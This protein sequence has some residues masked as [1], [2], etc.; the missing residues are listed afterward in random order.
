MSKVSGSAMDESLYYRLGPVL[1][2][3]AVYNFIVGGRGIGKTFSAKEWGISDYIKNGNQFIYLRRYNTE[4]K[5]T[6][7]WFADLAW[8]FPE[9][10]FRVNGGTAEMTRTPHEKKPTWEIIGFFVALSNAQNKKSVAYP[11][12]TKIIFDEF[13]IEKGVIQYLPNEARQMLDFYSTVDRYKD[14]TRVLFLA[15]S[16]SI[17]NPYFMEY[18]I[19]PRKNQEWITKNDGFLV[20]HLPNDGEFTSAVMETRF[21]KFVTGTEY[22]DYSVGNVFRDN[23]M[24]L[25]KRKNEHATYQF[26]LETDMG[27]MAV[28][29]DGI[30]DKQGV[31]FYIQEKRPKNEI[32]MTMVPDKMD[33]ERILLHY[34][35]KITQYL[36]AAF[37]QGR[38]Y[39]D[40]PKTRNA[41]IRV[42]KR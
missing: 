25:I 38:V 27:I 34:S 12:V 10:G 8:K 15:N 2:R 26:T 20:V 18:N 21:G 4:L 17:M 29:K 14:K 22:Y 42:F 31:V 13:I 19:E 32:I 3:N 35:D 11:R 5:T 30:F 16:V 37:K 28:W 6:H 40:T 9:Y 33:D 41:F 23:H 7:T 24:A 39:F 36:R 1:S